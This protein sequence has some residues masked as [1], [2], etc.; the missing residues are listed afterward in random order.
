LIDGQPAAA[1][2]AMLKYSREQQR[3]DKPRSDLDRVYKRLRAGYI[4]YGG[5]ALREALGR[6]KRLFD[7]ID[8]NPSE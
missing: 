3:E 1:I 7:A 4:E 8:G 5:I 2:E 6:E